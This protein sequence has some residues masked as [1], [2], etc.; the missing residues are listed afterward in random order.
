MN[1]EVRPLREALKL[2]SVFLAAG[3]AWIVLSDWLV[4]VLVPDPVQQTQLQTVKGILFVLLGSALFAFLAYRGLDKAEELQSQLRAV[5]DQ[6]LAGLYVIQDGTFTYVNQRLADIF[7]YS[8]EEMLGWPIMEVVASDSQERVRRNVDRRLQGEVNE[9]RYRLSGVRKDGESI[10]VEVHGR[11]TT[12]GGKPAVLGVLIDVTEREIEE[13]EQRRSQRLEALGQLTGAVAHDFNNLL[14][15]IVAPLDMCEDVLEPD[16][17]AHEEVKEA[18]EAARRAV[19]LTGQLLAFGQRRLHRVRPVDLN[20]L[21]GAMEPMLRRATRDGA[22]IHLELSEEIPAVEIDPTHFDQVLLNLV[23]NAGQAIEDIGDIW[24]RTD[25][26]RSAP[27]ATPDVVLE[28]VDNGVGMDSETADKVFEPFFTTKKEGTGL[29]LATV[30]GIVTQ[31][32]G[33]IAVGSSPGNG[34]VFT[35]RLPGT[36]EPPQPLTADIAPRKNEVLGSGGTILVIDDEAAVLRV[37]SR[38][39]QRNGF[40]VLSAEDGKSAMELVKRHADRID[41]ALTDIGLPDMNGV[42]LASLIRNLLPEIPVVY[43]SGRSDEEVLDEVARQESAGYIEKPFTVDGL[44]ETVHETL[45]RQSGKSER[46]A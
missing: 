14:T 15:A 27:A 13:E 44:L 19:T 21:V 28:I 22:N 46:R 5:T 23:I 18:K 10:R 30:H 25:S 17:P 39:L 2:G 38:I 37:A 35:V 9:L 36:V 34:T 43:M 1:G 41:S 40:E 6:N 29:G 31:A 3:I 42:E 20:E 12:W 16:H 7:G 8:V 26:E 4:G 32:G 45:A 11:G 24:I 33:S